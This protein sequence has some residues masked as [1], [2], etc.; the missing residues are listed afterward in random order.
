MPELPVK[1]VRLSELHL[2]ELKRDD[3]M[4]ALSEIKRPDVDLGK[5]ERPKFDL[6]DS[7]TK[8]E[9]PKVDLPSMDVGKA[10]AG[11]AAAAHIGRRKQPTRWPFAVGG[12][13]V[14]GLATWAILTNETVRG[15]IADAVN[16]VRERITGMRADDDLEIDHD[17]AIAF[18]AAETHPIESPPY[19]DTETIVGADYPAGLG[20]NNGDS[21]PAYEESVPR[22]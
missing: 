9:W 6:P 5:L 11:A 4:R 10:M 19:A 16:A 1:E 13:I 20:S 22:D 7:V 15:R 2:P 12:L 3:I 14:A 18:D 8:F 17:D 21:I